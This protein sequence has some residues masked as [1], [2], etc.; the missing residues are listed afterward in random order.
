MKFRAFMIALTLVLIFFIPMAAIPKGN[1][2]SALETEAET[3]IR[4]P[5]TEEAPPEETEA[6]PL[7]EVFR[8]YDKTEQK[9]NEVLYFDYVLG[10]IAAEMGAD[11]EEEAL[12]AQGAAAFSCALYQKEHHLEA[13]YDFT[14]DPHN[15]SGY[16][17]KE[18]IRE[19]YGD[20][21]DEKY[22]ILSA[23][24]EKALCFT[25]IYDGAPAMTVYHAISAG[26][27]ESAE[28]V[29]GG[30][31]P[32]LVP[33]ESLV[34]KR[35]ESYKS[36]VKEEK[37]SVLEKLNSCGAKLNGK[38]PEEWF[39]GAEKTE[40]GYVSEIKIGAATFSG[41]KLRTMFGLRSTAFDVSYF[42]GNFIFTVYGYGHGVGM[43]Q[44]GA[45]EMAKDGADFKEILRHYY[46]GA[47]I[48]SRSENI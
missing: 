44:I 16:V 1:S 27:T 10:A 36:T 24:A 39:E 38:F 12:V 28:N 17:T 2:F 41:E 22:E 48:I 19:I 30:N 9:V 3:K 42:D 32:Y 4:E 13:E 33:V 35:C 34:D 43:S 15:K 25:V 14:A 47:E 6:E 23:A 5:R 31:M 7:P 45:N 21:F 40:S 11:F 20:K 18:K 26:T 46:P 8:I 37:E 29:W